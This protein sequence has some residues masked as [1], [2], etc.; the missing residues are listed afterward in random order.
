MGKMTRTKS[1]HLS[2]KNNGMLN[3]M[4][5]KKVR[6]GYLAPRVNKK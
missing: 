5:G 1:K 3:R 2:S 4:A 6:R